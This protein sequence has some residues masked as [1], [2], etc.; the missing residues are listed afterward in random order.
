M[1]KT[2]D[3][4][5]DLAITRELYALA[6]S[7]TMPWYIG[8][9]VTPN[10]TAMP[11]QERFDSRQH[12]MIHRA[13]WEWRANSNLSDL[14]LRYINDFCAKT[15]ITHQGVTRAQFNLVFPS[16]TGRPSLPHVDQDFDHGVLLFYLHDADGDTLI[17]DND[18]NEQ[19]RVTPKENR[20]LA[21]D[22]S[23]WHCGGTPKET[24]T[25]IVLNCNLGQMRWPDSFL[26]REAP[27]GSAEN[28]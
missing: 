11:D 27:S 2:F 14:V 19:D 8:R 10:E 23:Q 9:S 1:Y 3:D 28:L 22:G 26:E 12:S 7:K 13:I 16:P 5:A 18:Y 20:V 15:G 21:F 17:I 24:P 4:V 6:S 25:R